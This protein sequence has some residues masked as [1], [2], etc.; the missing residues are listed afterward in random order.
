MFAVIVRAPGYAPCL[1]WE[2]FESKELANAFWKKQSEYRPGF[3]YEVVMVT[4][5]PAT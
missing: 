2:I 5:L 4:S 3:E 1:H